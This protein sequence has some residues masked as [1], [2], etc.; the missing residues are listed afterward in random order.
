M[1]VSGSYDF[2]MNRDQ[3]IKAALRKLRVINQFDDP[4]QREIEEGAE[5]LNL[6]VKT[7]Q[8]QGIHLW[9]YEEI[10]VFL[11][12][13]QTLYTLSPTG[14]NACLADDL[15][16]TAISVDAISGTTSITVSDTT[17]LTVDDYIGIELDDGSMQ[18]TTI[19][20]LPGSNVITLHD[21]LTESATTD[22]G[23][24][25]YTS[26]IQKPM[27]V[28]GARRRLGS[29]ASSIT[30]V[31]D[32]PA[33]ILARRDYMDLSIKNSVGASTQIHYNPKI[34]GGNLYVWQQTGNVMDTLRLTVEYPIQDFDDLSNNPDF[35]VEWYEAI[36][37]NL[38][39]RLAP[40]Y[41]VTGQQLQDIMLLA[42]QFLDAAKGFDQEYDYV[43]FVPDYDGNYNA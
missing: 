42:S 11:A 8:T 38:A 31:V 3:V 32:V 19:A 4:T 39:V 37:F 43:Q 41:G 15:V 29:T 7:W 25:S 23:V 21:A 10:V 36:V 16:Q 20:T 18:W 40:E 2:T 1:A 17:D 5:A 13:N 30:G 28:D 12:N 24:Y 34:N 22:Y 6:L 14:D 33:K 27:R 9:K 35:P 26:K